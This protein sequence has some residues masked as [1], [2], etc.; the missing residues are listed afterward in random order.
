ML[1]NYMETLVSQR[2]PIVLQ[3]MQIS[4]NDI[5]IDDIKAIALN[6]LPVKYIVD[7]EKEPYAKLETLNNQFEPDILAAIT[8]AVDIVQKSPRN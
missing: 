7:R 5:C 2:V 1:K 8:R 4:E 6:S 3:N